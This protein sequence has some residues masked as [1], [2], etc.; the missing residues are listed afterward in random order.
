MKREYINTLPD[1]DSVPAFTLLYLDD[2]NNQIT[3]E[4]DFPSEM[5]DYI[6]EKNPENIVG[7]MF[8][9]QSTNVRNV[10]DVIAI[11]NA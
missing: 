6:S 4:C 5:K 11:L 1:H 2:G 3:C 7:F 9:G 8:L 10:N